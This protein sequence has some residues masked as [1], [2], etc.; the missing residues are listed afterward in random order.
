MR[1]GVNMATLKDSLIQQI[2]QNI[3]GD[4]N[5][6]LD[7]LFIYQQGDKVQVTQGAF[8]GLEAVYKTKDSLERC[9]ILINMLGQENEVAVDNQA[10][11]KVA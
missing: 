11:E 3:E 10:I 2:K 8:T 1:F 7:D 5:K 4:E 9:V 6:S